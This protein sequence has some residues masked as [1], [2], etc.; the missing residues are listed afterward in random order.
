MHDGLYTIEQD[1]DDAVR[2]KKSEFKE[3]KPLEL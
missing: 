1:V 2:N 3:R